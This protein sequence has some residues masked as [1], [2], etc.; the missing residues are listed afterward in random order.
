MS[1][2]QWETLLNCLKNNNLKYLKYHCLYGFYVAISH[3]TAVLL[4]EITALGIFLSV[5]S[6]GLSGSPWM[7]WIL[8]HFPIN[9][10][11][12][13]DGSSLFYK[14]WKHCEAR[15]SWCLNMLFDCVFF[16]VFVV[17]DDKNLVDE[18]SLNWIPAGTKTK[19]K[20]TKN[21]DFLLSSGI[22][23]RY[24]TVLDFRK[25]YFSAGVGIGSFSL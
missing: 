7:S 3:H 11:P 2:R 14:D 20:Q 24:C 23:P 5:F 18:S 13:L 6:Q 1:V 10:C 16:G 19:K 15:L 4:H 22:S 17:L 12:R 9:S 25:H 21:C 8:P